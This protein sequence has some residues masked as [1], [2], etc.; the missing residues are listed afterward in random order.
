V[1]T[2]AKQVHALVQKLQQI[3]KSAGH[4]R[5][6]MIG[7]DQENGLTLASY[8]RPIAKLTNDRGQALYRL[9]VATKLEPNC[10]YEARNVF[11]NKLR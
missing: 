8:P 1:R 9:L 11:L 3:A 5:P 10:P 4:E 6:L 7:T 2:G